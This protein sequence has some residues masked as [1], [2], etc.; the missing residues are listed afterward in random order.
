MSAHHRFVLESI[1]NVLYPIHSV[2]LRLE[3]FPYPAVSHDW[4]DICHQ[5][6]RA[7][8]L[9]VDICEVCKRVEALER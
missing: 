3:G 6:D 4:E 7:L 1:S 9:S 5:L 8:K 2:K